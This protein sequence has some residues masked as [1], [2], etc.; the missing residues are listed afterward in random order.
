MQGNIYLDEREDQKRKKGYP[1]ICLL[2]GKGKQKSF[3]L[4][5]FFEKKDWDFKKQ[6]PKNDKRKTLLIR[7]KKRILEETLLKTLDDK[8]INFNNVKDIV[9]GDNN[10]IYNSTNFFE[11]GYKLANEQKGIL[12]DKGVEKTGNF[13]VYTNCLNQFKKHTTKNLNFNDIDYEL[14]VKYKNN[15]LRKGLA[16]NTIHLYIRTIKVIYDEGLKRLKIQVQHKPFENIYKGITI[17][18]NRTKKRHISKEVLKIL[19]SVKKELVP[20]QKKA[21]DLFLLQFYFGGQDLMDIFYLENKQIT[22][23]NRIIFRRG[24]LDEGG[25]EFDLKIFSKAKLILNTYNTN[26]NFVFNGRKDQ[27]GY[28]NMRRRL[29]SDLK[30]IQNKYNKHIDNIEQIFN[31]EFFRIEVLPLKGNLTTKVARHTFGTIGSRLYIE[32]DLLR[33]IMG[34]ERD[35]IDTIYKDVYPEKER[36]LYHNKI[37][38]T[39]NISNINFFYVYELQFVENNSRNTIYKYFKEEPNN[40][41]LILKGTKKKFSKPKNFSKIIVIERR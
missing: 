38:D 20:G 30:K 29:G 33:S 21:V 27:N 5:L 32:P 35:D 12:N 7:K 2:T 28:H 3:S 39:S 25:Y 18:K 16:K 17:K 31:K 11:F 9:K 26:E 23:N 40:E 8:T 36:D 19:E 13:N 15:L 24:K 1:V 37:I 41:Q 6:E 22:D 34:H 14:I 10:L 4:S